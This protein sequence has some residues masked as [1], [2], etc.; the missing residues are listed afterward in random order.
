MNVVIAALIIAFF[1]MTMGI[2]V[3]RKYGKAQKVR[4]QA[5]KF[6]ELRD[7]LQL[8]ATE[9]KIKQDSVAFSFLMF[10]LNLAIQ[11]AGVM[12]LSTLLALS[13]TINRKMNVPPHDFRC[14]NEEVQQLAADVFS[15]LSNMLIS[16]DGITMLLAKSAGEVTGAIRQLARRILEVLI[17]EQSKVV[18]EA[19]KYQHLSLQIRKAA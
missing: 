18:R 19:R 5:F 3:L 17:P 15:E 14:E 7:R 11:N 6:H 8:L 9:G 1:A 2:L 4:S 12:K 10:A 16:N 13:K